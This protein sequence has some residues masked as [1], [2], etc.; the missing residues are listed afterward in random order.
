LNSQLLESRL[1]D[2]AL[3][4]AAGLVSFAALPAHAQVVG[5]PT[6]VRYRAGVLSSVCTITATDGELGSDRNVIGS[7]AADLPAG[8][9]GSPAS[10]TI[11]VTSNMTDT[12]TLVAATPTL[13]GPTAAATSELRLGALAYAPTSTQNLAPNGSLNTTLDVKFGAPA[14]GFADGVYSATAIVTCNK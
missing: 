5:G 12:A 10:A 9:F 6:T 8:F 11:G 4:L 14:G 3:L 7:S 1:R 2:S 13:A